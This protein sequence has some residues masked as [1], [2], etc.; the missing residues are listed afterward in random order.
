MRLDKFLS[1]MC[2]GTRKEIKEIIKKRN[3]SVNGET[4]LKPEMK[5]SMSDEISVYG[6][7]VEY[8][9]DIYLMMN[10]PAGVI[11]ATHDPKGIEETVCDLLPDEFFGYGLF[12]VGRLDKDTTGLLL[13]T[14]DG[15]YAHM[16]TSPK[17]D[18]FKTYYAVC[19]GLDFE[20]ARELFQK[21]IRIDGGYVTKPSEIF[22][23]TSQPEE[24][25]Y[26]CRKDAPTISGEEFV[27]KITEGK[28]HQVKRM[29]E[30]AG[31]RV[32]YLKRIGFGKFILPMDLEEGEIM[33]INP[34]NHYVSTE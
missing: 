33:E 6:E 26:L 28:F 21:G 11:S 10:K 18:V 3:V 30:A 13:L 23:L 20:K 7:P 15:K 12:P 31:G 32:L 14:T 1:D 5:V 19:E 34:D 27:I 29:V 17:K 22:E 16:M 24:T 2:I 9:G 4:A 25:V 8:K